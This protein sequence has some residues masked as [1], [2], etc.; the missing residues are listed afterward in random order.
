[1][2]SSSWSFTL[3]VTSE[4]PAAEL[5]R[6]AASLGS[7]VLEKKHDG[8]GS[9]SPAVK[10]PVDWLTRRRWLRRL[11]WFDR[12][13]PSY[14]Q[15]PAERRCVMPQVRGIAPFFLVTD[16]VRAAEFYRDRLGFTIRGSF[17]GAP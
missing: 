1:M 16:V 12:L 10:K 13:D 2:M 8:C 17:F 5:L 9:N 11:C 3:C 7:P 6:V 15:Q 4:P 14:K